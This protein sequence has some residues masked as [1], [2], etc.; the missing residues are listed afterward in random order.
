MLTWN[1]TL[2]GH[3]L[4]FVVSQVSK[5]VIT[6]DDVRICVD[7]WHGFPRDFRAQCTVTRMKVG[8]SLSDFTLDDGPASLPAYVTAT[9]RAAEDCGFAS[10]W[11]MDHFFQIVGSGEREMLEAYTT[12]GFAAAV[13]TRITLGALVTGVTYRHPGVLAKTVSTLDVLSGGRAWLGIG[14]AW[15][16]REHLGLGVPWPPRGER[17]ERLEETLQI[18]QQMWSGTVGPF[19]GKHYQLAETLDSPPPTSTPRPRILVGGGGERKTLRLV[20]QYADACNIQG[21]NLDVLVHKLGV[22]QQHCQSLGRDYA[23]IEKTSTILDV[24]QH[25]SSALIVDKIARLAGP[26][27][28]HVMLA[29]WGFKDVSTVERIARDVLPQVSHL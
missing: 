22:L 26:G 21:S 12:L 11:V 20:A 28:Q 29:N 7:D 17:F 15:F 27:I 6:F 14:A 9:A 8:L 18:V 3:E 1:L 5:G 19:V 2:Y 13:T 25:M 16:E 10:L 24:D 4:T 23:E